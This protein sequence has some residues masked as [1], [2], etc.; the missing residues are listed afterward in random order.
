M[1]FMATHV[2]YGRGKAVVTSTGMQ[3]EFGKIAEMVQ[4]IGEE[5][6]PLKLRLR[7]FA[8]KL[9]ILV[10][11]ACVAIFLFEGLRGEPLIE[12][13]FLAV[14]L[15]VSAVPEGLPAIVTVTL[16]LGARGL[17]RRNAIIRRLSSASTLGNSL[18]SF[19]TH[20]L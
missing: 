16:A 13:F 14:A 7:R 20:N 15:A 9:G 4:V 18:L 2:V 19:S 5:E 8:K 17:A 3:T 11:F 10:T 1:I 6:T 12:S